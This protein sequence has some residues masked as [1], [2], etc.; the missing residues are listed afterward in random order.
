MIEINIFNN[1]KPDVYD[2]CTVTRVPCI[3]E[4]F[5]LRREDR[6]RLIGY[7]R[8]VETPATPQLQ[9]I[10]VVLRDCEEL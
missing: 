3:G 9:V 7:V 8:M 4:K 5:T 1:Q 2:K 10:D 6:S